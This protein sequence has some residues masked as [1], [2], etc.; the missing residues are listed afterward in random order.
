MKQENNQTKNIII[1]FVAIILVAVLGSIFANLGMDWFNSLIKP[2]EWIPNIIIP[3]IWT[4]IYLSFAVINF[5]WIKKTGIPKNVIILM[6]IN[7]LL[8]ILWCL[9]FFTLE[10]LFI[11]NIVIIVN[12]VLAFTLI[13]KIHKTEKLYSYLLSIYP[14]WLA[15]ATTLN[16]AV[17]ILN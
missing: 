8:N 12:L 6:V 2:S 16:L 3:I 4:I 7:G 17:W 9:T 5:L 1:S 14:I 15:I 10:E 13:I 11:G